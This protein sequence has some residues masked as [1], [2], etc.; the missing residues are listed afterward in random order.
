MTTTDK[1]KNAGKNII[2]YPEETIAIPSSVDS[3]KNL[4][5]D[6]KGKVSPNAFI[7]VLVALTAFR[8]FGI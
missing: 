8:W 6:P 5:R 1:L 4:T 3:I 2:G 7:F